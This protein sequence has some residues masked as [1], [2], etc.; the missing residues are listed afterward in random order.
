M[1]GL[2]DDDEDIPALVDTSE[3]PA[4]ETPGRS[5]NIEQKFDHPPKVP[6]TIVTGIE[7]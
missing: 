6:I 3:V 2:G 5:S 7:I 4:T 1:A